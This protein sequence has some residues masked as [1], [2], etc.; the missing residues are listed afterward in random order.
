MAAYQ[1]R[2][3]EKSTFRPSAPR[4]MEQVREVPRYHRY[5]KRA[6]EAYVRW[7][8]GFIYFHNK[9]HPKDMG[10]ADIEACLSHLAVNKNVA[11]STQNQAFNAL[12]F[13]YRKVLDL[14]FANDIAPVRSKKP[15]RLPVVPSQAE[16]GR[17]LACMSDESGLMARIMYD[18]FVKRHQTR[19]WTGAQS[20]GLQRK[21]LLCKESE[22]RVFRFPWSKKATDGLF[23][24]SSCMAAVY[25]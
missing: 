3:N 14:P 22:N 9:Q 15:V 17:L 6:E 8:K 13:L 25:A 20:N 4:L 21:S 12:L 18:A 16:A 7:I 10:K 19:P 11:A 24:T 5:G 23:T 2:V 1:N